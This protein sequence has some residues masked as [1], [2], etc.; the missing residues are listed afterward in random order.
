M[1]SEL[2]GAYRA[3]SVNGVPELWRKVSYPSLK[4]LGSYL[5]DLYKR[6]DMLQVRMAVTH[7]Q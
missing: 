5:E 1:S 3:L 6:L 4:P 2:E 7:S